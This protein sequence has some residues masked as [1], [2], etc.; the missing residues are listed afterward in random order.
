MLEISDSPTPQEIHT[1]ARLL[2]EG[3][4][5]RH[6]AKQHE[7]VEFNRT[8]LSSI[9]ESS[10]IPYYESKG[11]ILTFR[12]SGQTV[13][14]S[15]VCGCPFPQFDFEILLFSVPK[16]MQRHGYGY[17]AIKLILSE[18]S[19]KSVLA[20]C[21]PKSTYMV[22]LLEKAKF[23]EVDIGTSSNINYVFRS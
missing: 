4:R 18:V 2:S 7:D 21:M 16:K 9:H 8:Y 22:K 12:E 10:E 23:K 13:G 14:F 15:V 17:E 6:Y 1:F 20:R 5:G 3:A 11:Y 19:G